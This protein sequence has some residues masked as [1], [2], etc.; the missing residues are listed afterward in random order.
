MKNIFEHN[1]KKNV[2]KVLRPTSWWYANDETFAI[3]GVSILDVCCKLTYE[4]KKWKQ[5]LKKYHAL[6]RLISP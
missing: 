2:L 1:E 3:G 4:K 6:Q 5:K